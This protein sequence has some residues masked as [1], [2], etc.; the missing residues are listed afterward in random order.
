M[1]REYTIE[2][3]K[4]TYIEGKWYNE[5]KLIVPKAYYDKLNQMMCEN[6]KFDSFTMTEL[7]NFISEAKAAENYQMAI[8]GIKAAMDKATYQE[9]KSLL[10]QM[11]LFYKKINNPERAIKVAKEY[12]NVFGKRLWSVPLFTAIASAYYDLG[13]MDNAIEQANIAKSLAG[14]NLNMELKHLLDKIAKKSKN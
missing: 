5:A 8:A 1:N 7:M 10:P 6:V 14:P 11:V 2:G 12:L 9:I 13:D 3:E 4:F